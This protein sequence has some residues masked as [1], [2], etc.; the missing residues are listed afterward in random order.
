[1]VI[2]VAIRKNNCQESWLSASAMIDSGASTQF[3]DPDFAS[4]LGLTLDLKPIP[5]SL[6]VVDGREAAP[7]THTCTLD[8]LIDQHLETL[9]FQVTKLAGWQMILGKT[10]LKKHNPAINWTQNT[11]AFA[12][13]YCQAHCLP[14]R[15]P[16]TR[17]PV[18]TLAKP[19]SK[20]GPKIAMI[21]RAAFRHAVRSPEAELFVIAT[22]A[23]QESKPELDPAKH[24]DYPAN[25]VP[26]TYQDFMSLFAK[27]E[28]DKLPPHRY[29]D[30]EIPITGKPP[31]GRMYSMS[32]A[33]L[34]EI[35]KWIT[36]N[37]SKGF[38]RAASS[39]CAS[40]ILFV[41][42]K[43]GFLQLCV[44]F[45]ALH[46]MTLKDRY[47]LPRIAETLNQIY[48]AKYFIRLDLRAA[49]NL[50]GIKEGDEWKTTFRTR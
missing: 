47:P 6:I 17:D 11:V 30:H 37:L 4:Q 49:Y 48:G 7:L 15:D 5:E 45:R 33:E 24:P 13:G 31:L 39:S 41:K 25:I 27:K 42:T 32:D 10:W 46:D 34:A 19:E 16:V 43:D 21:S 38:I 9:T 1:M 50:I 44:D 3:I 29:V 28:A 22:S 23:I 8:L 20:G 18:P 2:P 40:P 12:S 36:E 14:T 26:E 35:R